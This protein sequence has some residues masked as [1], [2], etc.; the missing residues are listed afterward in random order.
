MLDHISYYFDANV[1][2]IKNILISNIRSVTRKRADVDGFKYEEYGST[3]SFLCCDKINNR[4]LAFTLGDS[5]IYRIDNSGINHINRTVSHGPDSVC[6]TISFCAEKESAVLKI[7]RNR[8]ESFLLCTD[9]MWKTLELDL[10]SGVPEMF[11]DGDSIVNMLDKKQ[12]FDDCSFL[13]AA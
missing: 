3:L 11:R 13:L 9:G 5:R 6:S 12:I 1:E 10:L 2:K 7:D 8:P 4:I